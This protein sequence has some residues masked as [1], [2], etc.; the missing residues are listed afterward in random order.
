MFL[1]YAEKNQLSVWEKEPVTSGS[2]NVYT[3]RFAFSP[4]WDGMT[5][6][7]IFQAG[8]KKKSVP[9]VDGVCSVPAE[10]LSEPGCCLMAGVCGEGEESAVLPTVWAN[11][12]LILKGAVTGDASE[13]TPPPEG[14][15]EE[16]DEILAG[17]QNII[18][19]GDGLTKDGDTLSVDNP[20]RGVLTQAEWDALTEEQKA[21]GTWFVDDGT[22][23]AG[24]G[25]SAGEVYSTEE[26]RIGTWIDGKPL[27]KRTFMLQTPPKN[28]EQAIF[29][30]ENAEF[31]ELNGY[32]VATSGGT[33]PLNFYGAPNS[34]SVVYSIDG[35][36]YFMVSHE[37]YQNRPLVLT[38][39][40][41]KTTDQAT[42]ELPAGL[43]T[44]TAAA[45]AGAGHA[46]EVGI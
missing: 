24:G 32:F 23:C 39:I 25:E 35:T 10:V 12:G 30:L 34:Y 46:E 3:V 18:T 38:G 27:Y 8:R 28:S 13:P 17:K 2:V 43:S 26:Q 9:L 14:W 15:Q 19:A 41:T 1:L 16:L 7:A 22:A 4:D 20:V 37:N 40:Y 5:R 29:T 21:S 44:P 6:T 11:L 33:M 36:I 31:K 42:I 45:A